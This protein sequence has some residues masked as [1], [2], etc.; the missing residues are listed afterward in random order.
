MNEQ[1]LATVD[2]VGIDAG[3]R[4]IVENEGGA[5]HLRSIARD[6]SLTVWGGLSGHESWRSFRSDRCHLPG[7]RPPV[8]L[9][10]ETEKPTRASRYDAFELWAG[11]H[12]D[13]TFS[14]QELADVSGFSVPTITKYLTES[15]IF[16]KVKRGQWRVR[17]PS[18]EDEEVL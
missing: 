6:G 15:L 18:T 4:L 3:Q 13:E 16:E 7:W 14:T 8:Q 11:M 10:A 9:D 2:G 12:P 1:P 5:F 17:R